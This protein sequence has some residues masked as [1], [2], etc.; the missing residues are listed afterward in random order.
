MRP[1]QLGL[2]VEI[3][4]S[5]SKSPLEALGRLAATSRPRC[6]LP[7]WHICRQRGEFSEFRRLAP[8]SNDHTAR[9]ASS[10]CAK[11]SRLGNSESDEKP[12]AAR[13]LFPR[14]APKAPTPNG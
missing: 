11:D 6:N 8:L 5:V 4:R 13:L 14:T 1:T 3:P 2:G 9:D 12:Y 10:T 7:V